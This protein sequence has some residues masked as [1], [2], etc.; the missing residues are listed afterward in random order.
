MKRSTMQLPRVWP[1]TC[2]TQYV[3]AGSTFVAIKGQDLN[4]VDFI[5]DALGRGAKKIIIASS[6]YLPLK[7]QQAI[8]RAGALL[9]KV[10]DTR[11]ALAQ[12][13]ARAYN[14]PARRLKIVA[15][16]GTKGKTTTACLMYHMLRQAGQSVALIST[17]YNKIN[18]QQFESTLTTPQPD[19]LH[20]FFDMCVAQDV[21]YVVMEVAAQAASLHRV[22]SIAFD[23]VVFTNFGH[24]HSEFYQ[25]AHHYFN[26]KM[27]VLSQ[28][29]QDA[30]IYINADDRRVSAL[31]AQFDNAHYFSIKD[32]AADFFVAVNTTVQDSIAGTITCESQSASFACAA[33]QG[34]FNAS[35]IIAAASVAYTLGV[36]LDVIVRACAT[37]QSIP[38]RLERYT[39]KNGI[40]CIIDYAHTPESYDHILSLLRKKTDHLTV[41][42]GA[43]GARDVTKRPLMGTIAAQYADSIFL[44]TDNPRTESPSAIVADIIRGISDKQKSKVIVEL[45]REKAIKHALQLSK[46]N[47]IIALLGK[48]PDEY[49]IIGNTKKVFSEKAI[50]KQLS[51]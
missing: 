13:S 4:G 22:H 11:R 41:V 35:N 24:E 30:P 12:S 34:D 9:E 17:V 19:Y 29:K 8:M 27:Q 15:I 47:G 43:G 3:G 21:E 10:P 5:L 37:M 25:T 45:D 44:T 42:F 14:F 32:S 26:A 48:G 7:I 33:L 51:G 50:I 16:T 23:A 28:A 2:H 38:G 1:V 31:K 39:V 49:Q 20:M 18:D 6:E 36:S 40:E 46:N